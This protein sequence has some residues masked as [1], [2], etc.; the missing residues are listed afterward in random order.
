MGRAGFVLLKTGEREV[1]VVTEEMIAVEHCSKQ[2]GT[3]T[4]LKDVSFKVK[5][6]EIVGL[7]GPNGAGKT[8]TMKLITGFLAPT[9]GR[10]LINGITVDGENRETREKIGYLPENAPL[11]DEMMVD[12]FL[13]FAAR[14]RQ[15]TGKA[16]KERKEAVI[17][18]TG[19]KTVLGKDIGTLS[20]GYRQRVG[21]AQAIIHD[22]PILILDEPT[23]GLDPNQIVDIRALIRQLGAEKTIILSTHIL[24][25]VKVTCNRVLIINSGSLVADDT[26]EN[27][28]SAQGNSG[29]M[30]G[31]TTS[32][33]TLPNKDEVLRILASLPA[34]AHLEAL[35]DEGNISYFK[36]ESAQDI[37]LELSRLL[38]ENNLA[39][40][41]LA[42][43]QVSLEETF[44]HLTL[45]EKK[46]VETKNA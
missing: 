21:L 10:V 39:I 46:E 37:R 45:D 32:S 44:R 26:P 19:I 4:A 40:M 28:I 38:G 41:H 33:G 43:K 5:R 31:L 2:Y 12:E 8:T 25:E 36:L 34:L 18:A 17:E 30:L 23:S 13:D 14:L 11:Y 6:G 42:L 9:S 7:L 22:P 1:N 3:F 16:A 35:P 20:K 15:L 24:P 27:L 29:L